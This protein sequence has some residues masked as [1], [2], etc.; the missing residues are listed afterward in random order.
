M[1]VSAIAKQSEDKIM[2]QAYQRRKDEIYFHNLELAKAEEAA[3]KAEQERQRAEQERQR[4][5]K[6]EAENEMLRKRIAELEAK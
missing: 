4:A 3:R 2:R 6:A 1:A 5:E